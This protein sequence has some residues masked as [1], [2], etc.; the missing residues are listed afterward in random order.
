MNNTATLKELAR[1]QPKRPD[2]MDGAT[3]WYPYDTERRCFSTF[4][5]HSK[6]RTRKECQYNI[7]TA[8]IND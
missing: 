6:H 1:F 4:L 2:L 3:W 5:T 7:D 8:I